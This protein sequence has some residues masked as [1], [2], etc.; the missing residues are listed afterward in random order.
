MVASRSSGRRQLRGASM[1][2]VLVTMVII[3]FGLLGMA[4][5]Q[6]RMQTSELESYQ[7]S[8]ALVL[9]NDMASRM[10]TNRAAVMAGS[11]NIDA[12]SPVGAGMVCSALP[13]NPT[14]VQRDRYDWCVGLQGAAETSGSTK[15]GAMIGGRGCV[16]NVGGDYMVTVAW[17]GMTPISAP[18]SSVG[19]G[20]DS[21][22]SAATGCVN[23]L[24][25]RTVTTLVRIANLK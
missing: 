14:A 11:Y 6:M 3:A 9:L 17:Q 5:L 18:P 25:R 21:Y 7:R 13:V 23:D 10:S 20:L 24:C 1:I 22:N 4:G 12:G 2:E 19:C 16:E 8:Q 15:V